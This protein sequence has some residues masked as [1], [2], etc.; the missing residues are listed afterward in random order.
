[1]SSPQVEEELYKYLSKFRDHSY[2]VWSLVHSTLVIAF[3][4]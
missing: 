1:M 2:Q 4:F 3:G